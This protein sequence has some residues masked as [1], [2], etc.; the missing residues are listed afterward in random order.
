[1]NIQGKIV[2]LRA[3][4]EADVPILHQ[5]ANDPDLQ[6]LLEGRYFPTPLNFHRDWFYNLKNEPTRKRFAVDVTGLGIIGLSSLVDIDYK[7]GHA[8]HGLMLGDKDIR[9]KGYGKDAVM[10]TMRYAFDELRLER[11]NGSRIESNVASEVFYNKLGWKDE[12]RR[13]HYYYRNGRFY[14]QIISRILKNDYIYV[15]ESSGYWSCYERL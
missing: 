10:T 4:E 7:N 9:G 8:H 14:D 1:M 13:T 6:E 11:L 2:T 5:W 3:I 12:G 15:V